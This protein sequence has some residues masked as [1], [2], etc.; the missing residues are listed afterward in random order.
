MTESKKDNDIESEKNGVF[1]TALTF[2]SIIVG[3]GI[4]SVPYAFTAA[5]IK[6]GFFCQVFVMLSMLYS[7]YLYFEARKL[8]R[9]EA[10]FTA[11]AQVCIGNISSLLVNGIIA[12]C[13]FGVVTLYSILFAT[14]ALILFTN[15]NNPDSLFNK[16]STYVI[17]LSM[18]QLPHVTRKSMH[19]LK[20]G[21]YML[22][23]GILCL[24]CLL[25]F[26]IIQN[27]SY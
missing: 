9:C 5:G 1:G 21:T 10:S 6:F 20:I 23:F 14:I 22:F 27:G 18:A 15:E 24:L 8:L 13:I 17:L 4:V 26:K 16:K 11:V 3:G 19:E 2:L 12:F 7:A 25:Q